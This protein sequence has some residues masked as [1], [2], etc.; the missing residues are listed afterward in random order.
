MIGD[1]CLASLKRGDIIQLQRKGFYRCDEEY[2]PPRYV[3]SLIF[4]STLSVINSRSSISVK[5]YCLLFLR[6]RIALDAKSRY[7]IRPNF[8][9]LKLSNS[10][11][12]HFIEL[13]D[14]TMKDDYNC[15]MSFPDF[16]YII[17]AGHVIPFVTGRDLIG[18][19]C[20]GTWHSAM[21]WSRW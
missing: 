16:Y 6:R 9:S 10:S 2:V 11:L 15:R 12:V 14:C 3:W 17:N 20:T 13:D 1:P 7:A 8:F 19:L 18:A 5:F 21:L 4:L